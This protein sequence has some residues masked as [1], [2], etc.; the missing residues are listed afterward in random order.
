M[1]QSDLGADPL[2]SGCERFQSKTGRR[3]EFGGESSYDESISGDVNG[4][5]LGYASGDSSL[6]EEGGE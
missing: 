3:G 4:E 2:T 1:Y 6:G 5:H